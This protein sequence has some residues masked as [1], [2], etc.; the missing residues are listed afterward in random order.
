MGC[1]IL[2]NMQETVEGSTILQKTLLFFPHYTYTKYSW[3][4]MHCLSGD[5][6][7]GM[8]AGEGLWHPWKWVSS[9]YIHTAA[10]FAG[11]RLQLDKKSGLSEKSG[12]PYKIQVVTLQSGCLP[13]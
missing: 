7:M 4:F 3:V 13:L 6:I 10:D 1:G 12:A 8:L 5:E 2:M 9:E 11:Q